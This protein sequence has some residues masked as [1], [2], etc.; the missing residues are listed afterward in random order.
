MDSMPTLTIDLPFEE[1]PADV[2]ARIERTAGENGLSVAEYVKKEILFA[3]EEHS[4]RCL[5][6]KCKQ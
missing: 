2:R 6:D 5:H 4:L 1:L 3:L